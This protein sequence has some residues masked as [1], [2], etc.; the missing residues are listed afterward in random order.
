MKKEI[1]EISPL[2]LPVDSIQ[3]EEDEMITLRG[4]HMAPG[5]GN[6]C[7]CGCSG[8]SAGNGND[9]NCSCS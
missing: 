8:G 3:L 6:D 2:E 4:G 1:V 9:C 5:S 7:N